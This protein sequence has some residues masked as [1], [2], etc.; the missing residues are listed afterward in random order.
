MPDISRL[1]NFNTPHYVQVLKLPRT[2]Q[3]QNKIHQQTDL[4]IKRLS[5]SFSWRLI[6]AAS[7]RQK[8]QYGQKINAIALLT[9]C[10][11]ALMWTDFSKAWCSC[12]RTCKASSNTLRFSVSSSSCC[13][14]TSSC[15]DITDRQWF[16]L[17][18]TSC[19]VITTSFSLNFRFAAVPLEQNWREINDK[20]DQV[21][22]GR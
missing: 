3:S 21:Q 12:A 4:S 17:V 9:P 5:I 13:L 16:K 1:Q 7:N 18:Q 22:I 19:D 6:G 10:C 15:C 14:L 8:W 2:Q 20:Q 11:L